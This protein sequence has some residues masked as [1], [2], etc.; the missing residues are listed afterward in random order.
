[1]PSSVLPVG[2]LSCPNG[3]VPNR[4]HWLIFCAGCGTLLS[5][6]RASGRRLWSGSLI[7]N[8]PTGCA[9]GSAI[10]QGSF[11]STMSHVRTPPT[12]WST[13]ARSPS[14]PSFFP[15]SPSF[16]VYCPTHACAFLFY[17]FSKMDAAVAYYRARF[18]YFILLFWG[19]SPARMPESAVRVFSRT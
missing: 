11:R 2:C 7:G 10:S 14:S 5:D 13:T 8:C 3:A 9:S 15:T 17:Y 6:R 16:G 12:T 1:M 19:G 18:Y 4:H